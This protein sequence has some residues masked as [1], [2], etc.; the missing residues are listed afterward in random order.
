MRRR[1]ILDLA[2]K[3]S[4]IIKTALSSKDPP[5]ELKK[6]KHLTT[7]YKNY[8]KMMKEEVEQERPWTDN[9]Q[10]QA[11]A[12]ALHSFSK[13]VCDYS[14]AKDNNPEWAKIF[15]L[16]NQEDLPMNMLFGVLNSSK[17]VEDLA[18]PVD[19]GS[20]QEAKTRITVKTDQEILQLAMKDISIVLDALSL[21]APVKKL[22]SA[23]N[24]MKAYREFM[25]KGRVEG[26]HPR[27]WEKEPASE[28]FC[29][30]LLHFSKTLREYSTYK[31]R[32]PTQA[33]VGL[34]TLIA[35]RSLTACMS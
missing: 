12:E 31:E 22:K 25:K 10:S 23:K 4:K 5:K 7:A 18:A 27:T 32:A 3:D 14:D 2:V 15:P 21:E 6:A 24:L 29:G 1:K 17:G 8:L 13:H 34:S 19:V 35:V 16:G 33:K 20:L 28:L 11:Y 30:G 9:P 26:V